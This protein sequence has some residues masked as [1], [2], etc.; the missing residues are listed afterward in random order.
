M[1]DLLASSTKL[2]GSFNGIGPLGKIPTSA[3]GV[4][5]LL[6]RLI[7]NIVGIMTVIAGIWFV[8][9]FIIG[10]IGWVTAGGDKSKISEAQ[11]KITQSIIGVMVVIAAIFFAD[12]VGRIIG[13]D[14]LSPRD[15]IIR[16][17][18]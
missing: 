1:S 7:S 17:W 12:I 8:F 13:L 3:G 10:A 5:D 18:L 11:A 15:Y 9:Q 14:I 2:G 16:L 4:V 6:S